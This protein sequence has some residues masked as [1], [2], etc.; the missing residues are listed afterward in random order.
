M[1][2]CFIRIAVS[3]KLINWSCVK[4]YLWFPLIITAA[5][6]CIHCPANIAK[7]SVDYLSWSNFRVIHLQTCKRD[8]CCNSV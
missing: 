5:T 4:K 6:V 2:P 1:A 8:V 3:L 7:F